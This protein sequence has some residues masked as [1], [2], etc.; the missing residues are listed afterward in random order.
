MPSSRITRRASA[1]VL[2][3]IAAV[4]GAA[5]PAQAATSLPD[6]VVGSPLS[7]TILVGPGSASYD[8]EVANNGLT[9]AGRN[10]VQVT[11][12]PVEGIYFNGQTSWI[13]VP[14]S[15]PIVATGQAPLLSAGQKASAP[16]YMTTAPSGYN[17][18]TACVDSTNVVAE[19]NE[20]NN[21][22]TAVENI[23]SYLIGG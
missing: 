3:A 14:G 13:N 23:Q 22:Q 4:A 7:N 19:S 17:R 12:Q 15:S 20:S 21:C 16:V 11:F 2:A 10:Q 1:T 8:V 18:V 6:L 5:V 9:G